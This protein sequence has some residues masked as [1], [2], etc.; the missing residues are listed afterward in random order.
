MSTPTPRPTKYAYLTDLHDRLQ[1][2][3]TLAAVYQAGRIAVLTEYS[4]LLTWT[5]LTAATTT[6]RA[7]LGEPA[8]AAA[9]G[10]PS[11]RDPSVTE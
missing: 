3:G 5:T 6:G 9:S 2:L 10:R 8:P 7:L 4:H 1:N 11:P